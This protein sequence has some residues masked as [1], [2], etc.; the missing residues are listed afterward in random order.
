MLSPMFNVGPDQQVLERTVDSVDVLGTPIYDVNASSFVMQLCRFFASQ[1]ARTLGRYVVFRDV[2]GLVRAR[3]DAEL[4]TA[5]AKSLMNVPDGVPLVWAA[6]LLGLKNIARVCGP[7]MML[8]VCRFGLT[9]GWRHVLFGGTPETLKN[10][11]VALKRQYPGLQIVDAISPPFKSQSAEEIEAQL[12]R[13]RS[14][15][16]HFVWVGLGSPKQDL[17]MARHAGSIAGAL[18]MGVGAAFDMHAGR[19]KRAPSWM[20]G[21]GIEWIYRISQDPSR[22]TKRYFKV[23]P[24]FLYLISIALI[25]HGYLSMRLKLQAHPGDTQKS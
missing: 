13:I 17:W 25:R 12:A 22:L 10:L 19:I 1:E 15:K 20:H 24:R 3:D 4:E 11:E 14:A 23:I 18:S 2:H 7:D 6:R 5:H 8:E 16:P 9:R 21:L